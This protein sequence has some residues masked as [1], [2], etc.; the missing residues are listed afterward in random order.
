[1]MVRWR[2]AL[3][4]AVIPLLL[5]PMVVLAVDGTPS[6]PTTAECAHPAEQGE[7][8]KLELV[9]GRFD[10]YPE[11]EAYLA[12]V[13]GTGFVGAEIRGDGCGR[14][15]V[16][17]DGITDYANGASVVEEARKAGFDPHLE[18]APG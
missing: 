5:Y 15:L 6:F 10:T 2:L 1:M 11:A 13:V 12:K 14:V 8:A 7:T 16:A 4:V 3:A 18:V 17:Y 9:W